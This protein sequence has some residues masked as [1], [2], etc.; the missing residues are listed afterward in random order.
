MKFL[1]GVLQKKTWEITDLLGPEKEGALV[2]V[3]GAVHTIRDMGP[4]AF[5]ILR[6]REGLLQCVYEPEKADFVLKD[7]KEAA[8]VEVSGIVALS[9]KAPNGVGIRMKS[10]KILSEPAEPMPIPVSKW[11][12]NVSLE[13]N[14]D[15]RPIS[16]RN[17]RE[18]AK[19]RIQE[20]I[21]RGFREFLTTQ[22]FTEIH[23][24][25]IGSKGAEEVPIYLN[26]II[27]TG[28]RSWHKALSFIS[29]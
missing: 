18:R 21:V 26:W 19:F 9:P 24:P 4:I 1:T 20:G 3:N 23:T 25:K 8:A 12:M 7:V 17:I 5:V 22:G 6:K 27:F 11:K 28:L 10:V 15:L 14:L 16:L 13:T 2:T 29:R